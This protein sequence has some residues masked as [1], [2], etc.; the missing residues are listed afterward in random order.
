MKISRWLNC[1]ELSG[2]W[3]YVADCFCMFVI[4]GHEA[5]ESCQTVAELFDVEDLEMDSSL[6][7]FFELITG[8]FMKL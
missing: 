5:E 1:I 6:Q 8:Y 7:M 4:I 2:T 3:L